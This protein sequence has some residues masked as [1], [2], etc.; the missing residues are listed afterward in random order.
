MTTAGLAR[1]DT[2]GDVRG[3]QF[4][5]DA[6]PLSHPIR[7]DSYIEVNNFYT[8]TVYEKGSEVIR[9]VKTL[10]SPELFRKG[11]DLYFYRHDGQ[12][13]TTEEFIKAMEDASGKDLKQFRRWYSQAG[14][15]ELTISSDYD[16]QNKKYVL[17]VEQKTPSTP[18]QPIKEPLHLPLAVGLVGEHCNDMPLQLEGENKAQSESKILEVKSASQTFTFINVDHKPVPSLL[19]GFSAPV[20]IH[21]DYSN[22]E[23]AWLFQC[24]CDAFSRFNAG[25]Q[26]AINAI[27]ALAAVP[28]AGW[29]EN[30]LMIEAFQH[31][32]TKNETDLN[33][34]SRLFVLPSVAYILAN[35][36]IKDVMAIFE[37]REFIK[38][39]IAKHVEPEFVRYYRGNAHSGPYEYNVIEMG[40]RNLKNMALHYLVATQN[41]T[42]EKLAY[43]QFTNANN[44]TDAMG[45]LNALNNVESKLR[46]EALQQFYAR[47]QK[48]PLVMNKWLLLQASSTLPNTLNRVREL[49]SHPGFDL[50]NPNNVYALICGFGANTV[51]FHAKDGEAYEFIADQVIKLD[52]HNPQVAARVIQPLT[53][54]DVV[55]EARSALMKKALKR[56]AEQKT[57]SPDV[58]EVITKTIGG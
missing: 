23:L 57:L 28:R 12:A 36:P 58:Y 34:L 32:L 51:R 45:A 46:E 1:L 49:L 42:Y 2:A 43:E 17:R 30:T 16:A 37:A 29:K 21:Y 25:Q 48:E 10:I 18:G 9:M 15:P 4:A 26:L 38:E 44:M 11:M 5:E 14:T 41:P 35:N 50:Y 20:K 53:K 27:S 39:T 22:E 3:R 52:P 19:R 6:S 55:D 31:V 33:V 8:A 54:W 47:W 13:V 7:P 24:D 40:K 56:I